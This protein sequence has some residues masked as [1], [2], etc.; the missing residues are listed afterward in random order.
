VIMTDITPKLRLKLS[1][2]LPLR[3]FAV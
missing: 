3:I 2:N 1:K